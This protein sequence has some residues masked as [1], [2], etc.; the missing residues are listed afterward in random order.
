MIKQIKEYKGADNYPMTEYRDE[1]P[2]D[3]YPDIHRDVF[4]EFNDYLPYGEY[5]F[6]T[7]QSIYTTPVSE[8][9]RL[10]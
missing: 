7:I 2:E 8:R 5:G 9:T 1:T 4:E 10:L 6:H 3:L